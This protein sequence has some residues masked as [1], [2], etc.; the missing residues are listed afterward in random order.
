MLQ[1]PGNNSEKVVGIRHCN[2]ND[3]WVVAHG[4]ETDQFYSWLVSSNGV[5]AD[6]VISE[7]GNVHTLPDAYTIGYLKASPDG[8]FLF[9][10]VQQDRT[11]ELFPFDKETGEVGERITVIPSYY[12]ASFSP[13]SQYLFVTID[14]P[15]PTIN[16]YTIV[17]NGVVLTGPTIQQ[18]QQ[19]IVRLPSSNRMN[20]RAMQ[21]GPDRRIYVV[22]NASLAAIDNPDLGGTFR[23]SAVVFDDPLLPTGE[24]ATNGLPNCIDSYLGNLPFTVGCAKVEPIEADFQHSDTSI[25]VGESIDFTDLSRENAK[26]WWWRFEGASTLQSREQNPKSIQYNQVG[27]WVVRLIVSNESSYDTAFSTVLVRPKPVANAGPDQVICLGESIQLQASGGGQYK[28]LPNEGLSCDNCADPLA[29]PNQTTLYRVVVTNNFGCEA[30]DS[31]LVE[32]LPKITVDVGPDTAICAGSSMQLQATGAGA[33]ISGIRDGLSCTDCPNPIVAPLKTTT[34]TIVGRGSGGGNC[35][36]V[37]SITVHVLDLPVADAGKDTAV[38]AGETIR[39]NASGGAAYRWRASA[40]LA[41]LDC[42]DPLVTPSETTWYVVTTIN[43]A[44]CEATDSVL[45]TLR[46]ALAVNAGEDREI[47]AGESVELKADGGTMYR[48]EASPD[49]SC[50]DCSNPVATPT[51]TTTY[52]VV[53]QNSAGCE[54]RDSVT[55]VVH[56]LPVADAGADGSVCP[57]ESLQLQARGGTRYR[58]EASPDLSCLDCPNPLATPS[59]SAMYVVTVFDENNCQAV[60]SVEVRVLPLMPVDMVREYVICPGETVQFDVPAGTAWDWTPAVGL[61]CT[62]CANPVASPDVTTLYHVVITGDNGCK[63]QDSVLVTVRKDPELVRL[64][65]A[66]DYKR[67]PGEQLVMPIE[68]VD[69]IPNSTIT[70]LRLTVDYDR[71]VMIMDAEEIEKNLA[72]TLL[73]GWSV[74]VVEA[75]PG[76]LVVDLIAPTGGT[77]SGQGELLRVAGRMYISNVKGTEISFTLAETG[78]CFLFDPE[79]GFAELDDVCGLEFRLIEVGLEKYVA[80]TVY[81]NPADGPVRIEFGLGLDGMVDLEIFDAN[82]RQTGVLFNGHLA[83]GRYV[84]EWGAEDQSS[85]MYYYRLRSGDW[86]QSGQIVLNR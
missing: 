69:A 46:P 26:Q 70:Q 43:D 55:V 76:H 18:T 82:G 63:Q 33:G 41:C 66:R 62:D 22:K 81:P 58:W 4:L 83:S 3:Y 19:M 20:L 11:G 34:Y 6:P 44:G 37:D 74:I 1:Q 48:W 57:G 40:D 59:T 60:D 84:V 17:N 30:E 12:A 38:C 54:G 47:C 28:W 52:R 50:L 85:G 23:D 5:A 45:V 36:G 78:G 75:R 10:V 61:T 67:L 32:V 53:V 2:G 39:L 56:P 64:H 79:P 14:S 7:T 27:T 31:V 80:P 13:N 35:S 51:S 72:G 71:G 15:Q 29:K 77:L 73:E 16:R 25:C 49:L 24:I 68:L 8:R 21:I 42:P 9:S 65:I 86:V